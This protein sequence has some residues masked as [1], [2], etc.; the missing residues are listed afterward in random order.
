[1]TNLPDTLDCLGTGV[2]LG[3]ESEREPAWQKKKTKQNK[4]KNVK[5]QKV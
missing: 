3:F 5:L 4:T 1:M 2:E